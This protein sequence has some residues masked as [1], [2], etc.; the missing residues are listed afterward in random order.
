MTQSELFEVQ[1]TKWRH[2]W[3]R[4]SKLLPNLLE[5]NGP[6]YISCSPNQ[7]LLFQSTGFLAVPRIPFYED[8]QWNEKRSKNE[9]R[10][11]CVNKSVGHAILSL[12]L[13]L[14][15]SD[16]S[17]LMLGSNN[18]ENVI[19]ED[20]KHTGGTGQN[21]RWIWLLVFT[22]PKTTTTEPADDTKQQ[23]Q[24]FKV[25]M[26]FSFLRLLEEAWA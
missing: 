26:K 11:A 5:K 12:S 2:R 8:I 14:L 19:S 13:F 16:I 7:A 3:K 25:K 6:K 20:I 22:S 24:Q 9:N 4:L 23:T 21:E 17:C 15:W 1:S 10:C 18:K